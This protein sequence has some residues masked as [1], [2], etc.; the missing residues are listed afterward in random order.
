MP[1]NHGKILLV[2]LAGCER[3]KKSEVEGEAK[4]EA[5]EIYGLLILIK[6]TFS[7]V[8]PFATRS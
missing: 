6:F 1:H 5:I 8:A 7:P 3:L 4:K 2:D